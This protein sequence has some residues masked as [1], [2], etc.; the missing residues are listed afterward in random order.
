MM[1]K[2]I[3]NTKH[4]QTTWFQHSRPPSREESSEAGFRTCH[5]RARVV[6][7]QPK[8]PCLLG[9][10]CS[11][12]CMKSRRAIPNEGPEFAATPRAAPSPIKR[13][14]SAMVT[15]KLSAQE[16]VGLRVLAWLGCWDAVRPFLQAFLLESLGVALARAK[17]CARVRKTAG[18]LRTGRLNFSD[19]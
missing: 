5:H 11:Q 4:H 18:S 12:G 8:A 6:F 10:S 2:Y 19:L 3:L 1:Y 14:S 17:V 9:D 7:L 15:S 16:R 13:A